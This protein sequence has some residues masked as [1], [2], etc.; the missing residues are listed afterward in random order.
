MTSHYNSYD[1]NTYYDSDNRVGDADREAYVE[2][3]NQAYATGHLTEVDVA[4]RRDKAF[5]ARVFR[6]LRALVRDLP[7]MTGK[8][9]PDYFPVLG[10]PIQKYKR[11]DDKQK[12]W[13]WFLTM[14]PWAIWTIVPTIEICA[15]HQSSLG[16]VWPLVMTFFLVTGISGFITG[17]CRG[18]CYSIDA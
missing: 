12:A 2:H 5:D 8:R 4:E 3:L 6:D 1:Y 17:L 14:P 18:M 16:T 10:T 9:N 11:L 15:T 7:P 13:L